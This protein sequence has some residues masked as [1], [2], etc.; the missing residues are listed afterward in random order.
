[1]PKVSVIIPVYNKVD[2]L[3]LCLE[4]VIGQTYTDFEIIAVDD[5]STDGSGEILD[6]VAQREKRLIVIHK[7]NGGV[8]SAR[9]KGIELS[10]GD[11]LCFVDADDTVKPEF[12]HNLISAAE[13]EDD[14]IIESASESKIW[15]FKDIGVYVDTEGRY[16]SGAVVWGKLYR[17]LLIKEKKL[18]F[19]ESVRFGE[20]SEF[21]F[22]IWLCCNVIKT[23]KS[24]E[25][26]YFKDRS[27]TWQLSFNEIKIKIDT[28]LNYYKLLGERFQYQYDTE[29]DVKL[30]ISLYPI[31]KLLE[32]DTEY[33]DLYFSYFPNEDIDLLFNHKLCSPINKAL[34]LANHYAPNKRDISKEI[35]RQL[36]NKYKSKFFSIKYPYIRHR[37]IGLLL[38]LRLLP[39]A[40]LFLK[41]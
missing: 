8:S 22:A 6:Q 36:H 23:V 19:D 5:G 28:I 16:L 7:P 31:D 41:R 32:S 9:N 33:I 10:S 35:L 21:N 40:Y 4:S 3:L 11:Y 39:I 27:R 38:G 29:N 34:I 12:L 30:L 17:S 25:Y 15:R 1:M 37:I 14:V 24:A 18:F 13:P 26:N 20:D 2:R